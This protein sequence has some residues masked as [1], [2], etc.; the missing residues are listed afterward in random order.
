MDYTLAQSVSW[1][2]QTAS[3]LCYLHSFKSPLSIIYGYLKST[4]ILLTDNYVHVKLADFSIEHHEIN[5]TD[6]ATSMWMA[7]EVGI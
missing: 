2:S 5:D 1:M 6:R 4:N 7:P 3:A